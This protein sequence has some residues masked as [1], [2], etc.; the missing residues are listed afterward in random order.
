M[1]NF[2]GRM[3]LRQTFV[4]LLCCLGVTAVAQTFVKPQS[5]EV[6]QPGSLYFINWNGTDPLNDTL[7]LD[8][9]T[10]GGA[11]WT[12]IKSDFIGSL[13]EQW[14]VPNTMSANAIVRLIRKGPAVT[15]TFIDLLHTD[16]NFRFQGYDAEFSND[17]TMAVVT[18]DK[19][20]VNLFDAATGTMLWSTRCGNLDPAIF[21]S[22][23]AFAGKFTPDDS[24]IA[25]YTGT[26]SVIILN[27][28]NGAKI[29]SWHTNVQNWIGVAYDR[30]IEYSPDG[31]EL[32]VTC[33]TV[34]KVYDPA[35]GAEKRQFTNVFPA[36]S[37]S[38]LRWTNDP[39]K[40]V[41]CG[42]D[43]TLGAVAKLFDATTGQVL[44]TFDGH[45][46][47]FNG[48][49]ISPDNSLLVTACADSTLRV[50]DVATG[51]E[52]YQ[53]KGTLSGFSGCVFNSLGSEIGLF[54]EGFDLVVRNTA[55]RLPVRSIA[56]DIGASLDIS[57]E[58][59]RYLISNYQGGRIYL[60]QQ[61]Q[62]IDTIYSGTF[63]IGAPTPDSVV[64]IHVG[65]AQAYAGD[66]VEIPVT[67][68]IGSSPLLDAITRIDF[69]LAFDAS[70]LAPIAT[71]PA[72]TISAG[73]RTLH[74]EIGR[75][76][77]I[78]AIQLTLEFIAALG[79][80]SV[81]DLTVSNERPVGYAAPLSKTDGQFRLLGV[82]TEGG[83]RFFNGEGTASLIVSR[84]PFLD[85]VILVANLIESGPTTIEIMDASGR[86]IEEVLNT[87]AALGKYTFEI[88]RD[89]FV[90]G[91]YFAILRT[92]TIET[93]VP[94][95]IAR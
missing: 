20:Y 74:F 89:R 35:T 59:N 37:M 84:A 73:K 93:I 57:P 9:S 70:L 94:I 25:V 2:A 28:A 36:S 54:G 45:V 8:F 87:E 14:N 63:A 51:T 66:R 1:C 34:V 13:I 88:G 78:N 76:A 52:L 3:N 65:S 77:G 15:K 23:R 55:T 26:D 44:Q 90:S 7:Q 18:D 50:W 86:T 91:M 4:G 5:G 40:M 10:D 71:T 47:R 75:P 11:T 85:A 31:S 68:T 92:P 58:N 12:P 83:P 56:K 33:S 46:G 72:G 19:G 79:K 62:G 29:R 16:P 32:A 49:D 6:I 27:A 43:A 41:T 38:Y 67:I 39:T 69:D 95:P 30:D 24:Q 53:D 22:E 80:D 42:A 48:L 21:I 17:G 64:N 61:S 82:C 81:T 60:N